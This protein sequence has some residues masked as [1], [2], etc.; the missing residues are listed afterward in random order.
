MEH[1]SSSTRANPINKTPIALKVYLPCREAHVSREEEVLVVVVSCPGYRRSSGLEASAS[2]LGHRPA[3]NLVLNLCIC[4]RPAHPS[5]N[6]P[7]LY[8]RV[9]CLNLNQ[10]TRPLCASAAALP[11]GLPRSTSVGAGSSGSPAPARPPWHAPEP[12]GTDSGSSGSSRC[13][14]PLLLRLRPP[15]R[16]RYDGGVVVL[17]A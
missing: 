16:L 11:R 1:R 17:R 8:R 9:I 6:P 7:A 4:I 15:P 14:R 13:M 5:T 3:A 12:C 2:S 10:Q